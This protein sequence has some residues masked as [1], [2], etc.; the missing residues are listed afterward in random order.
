[1]ELDASESLGSEG[2]EVTEAGLFF[3]AGIEVGA[4]EDAEGRERSGFLNR[5]AAE[6]KV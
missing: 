3:E 5:E 4:D 6:P 1:M 2:L